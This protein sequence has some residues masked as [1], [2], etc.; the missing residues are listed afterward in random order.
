MPKFGKLVSFVTDRCYETS[1]L[2]TNILR[3]GRCH[4]PRRVSSVVPAHRWQ[5]NHVA[6]FH[7][8]LTYLYTRWSVGTYMLVWH[9]CRYCTHVYSTSFPTHTHTTSMN[10]VLSTVL[11]S[12]NPV[13]PQ[14]PPFHT[15]S[16]TPSR[17]LVLSAVVFRQHDSTLSRGHPRAV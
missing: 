10:K 8:W 12:H 9:T 11:L 5:C 2:S 3:K 14:S 4:R 13:Q 6:N 15:N 16:H 7:H 17:T 1:F